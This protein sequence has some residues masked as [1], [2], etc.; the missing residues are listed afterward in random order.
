[1]IVSEKIVTEETLY[2]Y[3][4]DTVLEYLSLGKYNFDQ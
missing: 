3:G 1:M 2:R 4:S